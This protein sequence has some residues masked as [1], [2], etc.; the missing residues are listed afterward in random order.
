MKY[1][2]PILFAIGAFVSIVHWLNHFS[3]S[4]DST[5]Y[6]T[7]SENLAKHNSL[8][9]YAN[10]PS[11]SFEP[12]I[13]PY[14]EYMP[15]LP[16]FSAVFFLFTDNPDI[17]MLVM[18]SL[19]IVLV[20]LIVLLI[21]YELGFNDSLKIIFLLFLTF[22]EPFRFICSN[23]WTETFFIFWSL[24]AALFALKLLKSDNKKYWIL[25]CAAVALSAFIKMY[26][27]LNCAF[28]IIP[29]IT[30]RKRFSKLITFIFFS[31]VFVIAWYIRNEITYGYFTSSHKIFEM[32]NASNILRPFK[33][34]L[35]L[36]GNNAIANVWAL[37]LFLICLSPAVLYFRKIINKTELAV[38]GVLVSGTI[39]NFLGIY[40][41]SLVSS[42]DYLE[43]RL[44]APVYI[45]SFIVLFV[46]VKILYEASTPRF[47]K[48]KYAFIALPLIFFIVNP[49]FTKDVE[50]KIE[51]KYPS[52]HNLWNEINQS[53][54]VKNS[55]HYITDFNYIHQ[56]YGDKPQ[57]II[58]RDF[59]FLDIAALNKIVNTGKAPFMVLRNNELPYFYFERLYKILNYK[60]A[61]LKDKT[62]SVYLKND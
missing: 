10:W 32:Y 31:S 14:T 59:M 41:L 51:I 46:S 38:W 58:T 4:P 61:D 30:H 2:I 35:F 57:R 62:F 25:G 16:I 48:I 45:L 53:G 20:Y 11:R 1:L 17:V 36:L 47:S 23:F 29:F 40:I 28:F 26:G 19:S 55:S 43:S 18:N 56:I 54:I 42:F 34:T 8:F 22:F 44:L 33:W 52:E 21:L 15:G 3:L 12:K 39:V 5:N 7:A 24:L 37:I 27:A 49:A 13:E 50:T 9:V 6:I 60:K